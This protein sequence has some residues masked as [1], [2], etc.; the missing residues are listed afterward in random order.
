VRKAV[1][2][3]RFSSENQHETS[4]E[5]QLRNAK[6][7][8]E[9]SGWQLIQTYADRA[10]SGASP[11]R[12][13]YQALMADARQG[14]FE[15]VVA[16]GLDRLSRDQAA[17]ASL[18]KLLQFHGVSIFTHAEGEISEL[19]VGLKGTMNA[20]FLKDLAIKTHRGLEGRVL[21]GKSAGGRAYGY[22]VVKQRDANGEPIRGLRRINEDEA[23]IVRRIF[24]A[25]RSGRSPRSIARALNAERISGPHGRAWRDTTIRGHADRRTGILRNDLYAGRLVWN[26]QRYERNPDTGRRVARPNPRDRRGRPGAPHRRRGVA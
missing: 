21:Q 6:R 4:I 14:R 8:I 20:L 23:A 24:E 22:E 25:F 5:D 13:G 15:I 3:A 19:H 12:P 2:Y 17:V 11:L 16:E 1:I 18:F 7:L 10:I 9:K 26:R